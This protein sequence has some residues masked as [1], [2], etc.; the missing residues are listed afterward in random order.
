MLLLL[1]SYYDTTK[2]LLW[3]YYVL[4]KKSFNYFLFFFVP[5]LP[6]P[7][8]RYNAFFLTPCS[9]F[10]SWVLCHVF[11]LIHQEYYK[12][13]IPVSSLI[14]SLR[15]VGKFQFFLCIFAEKI[16]NDTGERKK[17]KKFFVEKKIDEGNFIWYFVSYSYIYHI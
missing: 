16:K 9:H 12:I 11:F 15:Y 7:F 14:F 5:R 1:C 6:L 10:R 3:Y 17:G 8:K 2:I 13:D 4:V